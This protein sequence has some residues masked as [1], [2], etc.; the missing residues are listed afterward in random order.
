MLLRGS[1][2]SSPE[3]WPQPRQRADRVFGAPLPVDEQAGD[4][5]HDFAAGLAGP[6]AQRALKVT[7]PGR[8]RRNGAQSEVALI[9]I[10]LAA[11]RATDLQGHPFSYQVSNRHARHD[12][13]I[14]GTFG[15]F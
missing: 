12:E 2:V 5:H 1:S 15:V 7:D 6:A 8:G 4:R 14:S 3:R 13:N 10:G 9:D 11:A